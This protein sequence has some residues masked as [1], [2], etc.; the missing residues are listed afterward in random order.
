MKLVHLEDTNQATS[1]MNSSISSSTTILVNTVFAYNSLFSLPA[2]SPPTTTTFSSVATPKPTSCS[3]DDSALRLPLAVVY[4]LL[5]LL[6][7]VG[8]LFALWV[9]I[10]VHSSHNSLRVFLINCA[11]ADL[12]LLACLPFRII[13]H[14]IGNRWLLGHVACK[15]VGNLFYMNMYISIMI[16]GFISLDRYLRLRGKGRV[17]KGL[18]ARLCG[19]GLPCSWVACGALWGLSL[20]ALVPMIAMAEDKEENDKCFQFKHRRLA[21]GKAYFNILL[22]AMFWFVFIMLVVC[23]AKI[24]YQ[25]MKVSRDKPELPNAR[26]YGYTA[27]KSFFVLFLFTL[28]FGPYHIFRPV[29]I[30]AQLNATVTCEYLRVVD[31]I[32][33][34]MLLLSAFNSCLDPVMYFVL[35][36]SVRKTVI[37]ALG[38]RLGNRLFFQ[39]E[40]PFYSSTTESR[41]PS[42]LALP[43][44]V[45]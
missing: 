7:L 25:L 16:L 28:C 43:R 2:T 39:N 18:G 42:A 6:G 11:V 22:V 26:R 31:H 1:K 45:D 10:F 3:L 9:F 13:Y 36:G 44:T 27:K 17:R 37:H 40:T 5:F 21:S 30:F 19:C 15:L 20:A 4:S 33:E 12:V 23:Y 24:T 41:R 34:V 14:I 32:N 35:S 29:Y 8:N 38:N